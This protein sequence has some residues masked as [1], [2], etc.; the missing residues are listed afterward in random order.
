MIS[1]KMWRQQNYWPHFVVSSTELFRKSFPKPHAGHQ[2]TVSG[3][4]SSIVPL[5][6]PPKKTFWL[7]D[8][9]RASKVNQRVKR[10]E[11]WAEL[12]MLSRTSL[13]EVLVECSRFI[14]IIIYREKVSMTTYFL[15][16]PAQRLTWS[17]SRGVNALSWSR[18]ASRCSGREMFETWTILVKTLNICMSRSTSLQLVVHRTSSLRPWHIASNTAASYL[19]TLW[20]PRPL[21]PYGPV[22]YGNHSKT[23]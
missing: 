15:P 8:W 19:L 10:D 16:E 23:S 2:L 14:V 3:G 13:C 6:R 21:L 22:Q 7:T 18:Q 4:T 1:R 17:I 11:L 12:T 9:F 20:H 5:L